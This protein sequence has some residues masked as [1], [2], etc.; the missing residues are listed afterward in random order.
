[1]SVACPEACS[2]S[3]MRLG[4]VI[5]L[6][7]LVASAAAARTAGAMQAGSA[8]PTDSTTPVTV[9]GTVYDS[10]ARA[11]LADALVQLVE[12]TRQTR[13][14]NATTDSL[15]RFTV[16]SVLPGRYAVGFFHPAVDA[17]GIEPP[18]VGL[19][20]ASGRPASVALAIPGPGAISTALCGAR[21]PGDSSG[22]LV[23]LVRDADTGTPLAGARV[24]VSWLEITI[25]QGGIRQQQRRVPAATRQ[26]GGYTIC[27]LPNDQVIVSA[28]SGALR[29]GLLEIDIPTRGLT[30]RDF[31]LA[32]PAAAVATR[33]DSTP[34]AAAV[35][36]VL[37]GTARLAGQVRG[38]GGR[39]MSGARV[40]VWG[41]GLSATT[42]ASGDFAIAGLPAGT[43]SAQ[44][45]AI[46]FTPVSVP[47]DLA[48]NRTDSVA[49]TLTE[50]ATTLAPVTVY[51]KPSAASR[52]MQDF[53]ERRRQGWGRFLTAA[54]LQNRLALSDALRV[55]PGLRVTPSGFGQAVT[56]RGGC[57]PVVYLDGMQLFEGAQ[58][59][60]QLIQPTQVMGVEVYT[61]LGG[62]PPQ[63][64]SNGCGVILIWSQR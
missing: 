7:V 16:P 44:A 11:P 43:F 20:V 2:R 12:A 38:P 47:V 9:T 62:I 3:A 63:Y 58:N 55:V 54:D 51:G 34:G 52:F 14:Y 1:M 10:V 8:V 36:P 29:S 40:T 27:G 50:R 23:G 6:V 21:A 49:I 46:G 5:A 17:L 37:R 60:D 64:Q 48:S 42:G 30:R 4:A 57:T 25:G 33:V 56:A 31:T 26:D 61:G 15:G 59:I 32:G 24:V 35:A 22:T 28:D 41:S 13:V 18:L 45:R 19:T 39:P 53:L